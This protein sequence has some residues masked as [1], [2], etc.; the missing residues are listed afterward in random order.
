[1]SDYWSYNAN[2]KFLFLWPNNKRNQKPAGINLRE[3][4]RLYQQGY[5]KAQ[6]QNPKLTE[7]EFR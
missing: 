5:E 3:F 1:M 2:D 7:L 4:L 6:K